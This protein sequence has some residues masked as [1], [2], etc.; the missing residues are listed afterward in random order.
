M[1]VFRKVPLSKPRT[2]YSWC[3]C[4]KEHV[5]SYVSRVVHALGL[6]T[7]VCIVAKNAFAWATFARSRCKMEISKWVIPNSAPCY[8]DV[9]FSGCV[10][11]IKNS[12]LLC[13]GHGS[14]CRHKK[15]CYDHKA[16]NKNLY[17]CNPDP[18][19]W[20]G[21]GILSTLPY[22]HECN[23]VW[24]SRR[25]TWRVVLSW[26]VRPLIAII[27]NNW[28][29]PGSSWPSISIP[30]SRKALWSRCFQTRGNHDEEEEERSRIYSGMDSVA[31]VFVQSLPY[32]RIPW[33]G[34]CGLA[35]CLSSVWSWMVSLPRHVWWPLVCSG[36]YS[37]CWSMDLMICLCPL[38]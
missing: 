34:V 20:D 18:K 6:F 12:I 5:F 11:S 4:R 35:W 3:A 32:S 28:A 9:W 30:L 24:F 16:S 10:V 22:S 31:C 26:S 29:S 23:I 21:K 1:N 38:K 17:F 8:T 27:F 36:A 25:L 15:S 19:S 33:V 7:S 13:L 2:D 14:L 37:M